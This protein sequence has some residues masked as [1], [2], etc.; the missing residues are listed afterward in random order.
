MK[1]N[2]YQADH[3]GMQPMKIGGVSDRRK[4]RSGAM[5]RANS[6]IPARNN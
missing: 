5:Q 3:R 4:D 1:W 6:G 2:Y